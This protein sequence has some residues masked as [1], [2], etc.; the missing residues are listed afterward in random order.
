MSRPRRRRGRRP[1]RADPRRPSR[2]TDCVKRGDDP[3]RSRWHKVGDGFGRALGGD[4]EFLPAI[5][6][7]PDVRHGEETGAKPVG[8]HELPFGAMQ[9]FGL[10]QML[11]TEIM[12]RLLHRVERVRRTGE[13]AEL[14]QVMELLGHFR[15]GRLA[16]PENLAALEPQLGDRHSVLGQRAGLVRAQHRRGA[17]GFDGRSA[18]GQHPRPRDSP[19]A[20]RHE[21]REHDRELLGQHRHAER[22][23]GEQRIEPAAAQS[24]V[25]QHRQDAHRPPDHGEHPHKPAGLCLQPWRLGLQRAERL[26]DLADFAQCADRDHLADSGPAHDQRTGKHIRQV[27]AA[28]PAIFA[29]SDIAIGDLAHGHGLAGQQRFIGLQVVTFARER[30][31]RNPVALRKHDEIAAHH[32]PAGDAF[33]LAIAN[34][35]RT[36]AGQVAQRLQNALGAGLLHDGDQDGH[37]CEDEQDECFLQVS[38]RQIDHA[39]AEQQR[40]HRLTHDLE[41]DAQRRAPIRPGQLVVPLGLQPGLSVCLAEAL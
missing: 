5:G 15:V 9:M 3:R 8:V 17:E 34:D 6:G 28:R 10:G 32:L 38:Q 27:I 18:P 23:A 20:H 22:D 37:C 26:A 19:S 7:L 40:Q 30:V 41:D 21:D 13:N 36:R 12:K 14:D 25:E 35:Q 31:G 11:A 39:A 29:W 16:G 4:D 2:S 24:A 33:A 1:T